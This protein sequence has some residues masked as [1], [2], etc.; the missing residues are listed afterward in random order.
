MTLAGIMG[1]KLL[2]LEVS[3]FDGNIMNWAPFQNWFNALIH[4]NKVVDDAE[5]LTYLRQAL[6]DGFARHIIGGLSQTANN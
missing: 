3:T 1:V 4:S 2:K 6:K 5:K